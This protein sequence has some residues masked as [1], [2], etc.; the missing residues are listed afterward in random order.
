MQD[1]HGTKLDNGKQGAN[2]ATTPI[3]LLQFWITH[4]NVSFLRQNHIAYPAG[5]KLTTGYTWY[6]NIFGAM[7]VILSHNTN[8]SNQLKFNTRYT[9]NQLSQVSLTVLSSICKHFWCIT[10]QSYTETNLIDLLSPGHHPP[11]PHPQEPHE[12]T[13]H[14]CTCTRD[15][16][17]LKMSFR[18]CKHR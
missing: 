15:Q 14:Y 18:R 2:K 17:K 9:L 8:V 6:R 1:I 12:D 7:L 5:T 4:K 16:K 10:T 13:G 11:H 3:D